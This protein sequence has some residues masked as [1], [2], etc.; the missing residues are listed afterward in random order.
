MLIYKTKSK[1]KKKKK[2]FKSFKCS[3]VTESPDRI[4]TKKNKNEQTYQTQKSII[5]NLM[6]ENSY[7]KSRHVRKPN[8]LDFLN[9]KL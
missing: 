2:R 3:P 4:K 8:T 5:S 1:I 9:L 7:L 6:G